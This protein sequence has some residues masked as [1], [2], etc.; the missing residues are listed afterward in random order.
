MSLYFYIL[1]LDGIFNN[2]QRNV[3]VDKEIEIL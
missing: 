3:L 2:K 1:Q